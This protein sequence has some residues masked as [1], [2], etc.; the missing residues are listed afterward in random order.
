[1]TKRAWAPRRPRSRT[2][3]GAPGNWMKHESCCFKALE[4]LPAGNTR[5]R[6]LIK[7]TTIES[8][9]LRFDVAARILEENAALFESLSD[10]AP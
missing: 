1:M 7:L 4:Q 8:S 10:H 9:D 5:A 6:A 3:I 2:V